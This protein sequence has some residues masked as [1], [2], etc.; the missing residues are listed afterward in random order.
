MS[1]SIEFQAGHSQ[2][3]VGRTDQVRPEL[4]SLNAS[5]ACS[6]KASDGFDPAE[7]LLHPFAL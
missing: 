7:N 3:V 4:R 6:G 5:V 1:C 2:Q